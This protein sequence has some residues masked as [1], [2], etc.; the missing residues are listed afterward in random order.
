M[1]L[2]IREFWKSVSIWRSYGQKSSVLYFGSQCIIYRA[3]TFSEL[4][5]SLNHAVET[6]SHSRPMSERLKVHVLKMTDKVPKN[7]TGTANL[8]VRLQVERDGFCQ[9]VYPADLNRSEWHWISFHILGEQPLQPCAWLCRV[10]GWGVARCMAPLCVHVVGLSAI[11]ST[12]LSH[13]AHNTASTC[14]SLATPSRSY[15][16]RYSSSSPYEQ[17]SFESIARSLAARSSVDVRQDLCRIDGRL[18]DDLLMVRR[19]PLP[20]IR[21]YTSRHVF[22]V[23]ERRRNQFIQSRPKRYLF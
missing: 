1:N 19:R 12:V 22:S 20:A 9:S 13:C 16:R 17:P 15:T 4:W 23:E 7:I 10:A 11:Y 3:M 18:G 8:T 2:S 21:S 6:E 14:V 5:T